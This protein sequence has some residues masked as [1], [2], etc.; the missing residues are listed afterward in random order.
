[1]PD[2]VKVTNLPDSGSRERVAFDLL[3]KITWSEEVTKD[4]AYWLKLYHECFTVV[5]GTDPKHL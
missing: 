1:M 2:S 5:G 3:E 4:R